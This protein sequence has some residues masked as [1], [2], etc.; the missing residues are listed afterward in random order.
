MHT[1]E[2]ILIPRH[3]YSEQ[4]PQVSQVVENRNISNKGAYLSV[5][6]RNQ[7]TK[8]DNTGPGT[9]SHDSSTITTPIETNTV[10]T[11]TE[12]PSV[13]QTGTSPAAEYQNEEPLKVFFNF[14]VEELTLKLQGVKLERTI[15]ILA[16]IEKNDRVSCNPRTWRLF[17]GRRQT[18]GPR[19]DSFLYNIQQN[20]KNLSVQD[21][22]ILFEL[23]LEPVTVAN[24]NAKAFLSLSN[25]EQKTFIEKSNT[26]P[27]QSTSSAEVF[28]DTYEDVDIPV[29]SNWKQTAKSDQ[30]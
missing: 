2:F 25:S 28:M 6:Q 8:P 18:R 23:K 29:P 22:I 12:V 11:E 24:T 21:F 14:V 16:M 17:Y 30:E 19:I 7:S 3:V 20:T 5:L 15:D 27:K 1:E 26:Q 10:H 4:Q 13:N 9:T